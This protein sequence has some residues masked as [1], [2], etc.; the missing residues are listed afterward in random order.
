MS[1]KTDPFESVTI[2]S[3]TA[4]EFLQNLDETHEHWGSGTRGA[5][6]WVF[7]GQ[8]DAKWELMPSLFRHWDEDTS[9]SYEIDLIDNFIT[10]VNMVN[11]PIPNHSLGYVTKIYATNTK[12]RHTKR[13]LK[14]GIEYD[15]SH[16]VFAIAQHS[17]IPTRLLDFTYNPLVAAYFAADFTQLYKDLGMSIENEA[18]YFN[19]CINIIVDSKENKD[20]LIVETVSDYLHKCTT[21]V[22]KL[23]RDIAVW[24][25]R[26]NDLRE[27]TL[28]L[29][30]HPY[31]EILNLRLQKGVFLCDT[32]YYELTKEPWR[33]FDV[34]LAKLVE[35]KAFI[36]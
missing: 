30:E 19:E 2:H 21:R 33:P 34:E 6:D 5:I 25:I 4:E 14:N 27:T 12:E 20:D 16:A 10:N 17:G 9:P 35:K 22:S 7:R 13:V 18:K 23:P 32:E 26:Y 36:N 3:N 11:L 24:A 8:N 28:R 15:F 31:A 29:L 1:A